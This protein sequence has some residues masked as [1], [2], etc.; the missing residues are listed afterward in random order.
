MPYLKQI[1]SPNFFPRFIVSFQCSTPADISLQKSRSLY[2]Q[3]SGLP[4]DLHHSLHP[5]MSIFLIPSTLATLL[6]WPLTLSAAIPR[7]LSRS[8]W[9]NLLF[10][11]LGHCQFPFPR[12]FPFQI[13]R[14][15]L[16]QEPQIFTTIKIQEE[17]ST[18]HCSTTF[19]YSSERA[20][21]TKKQN[22][23]SRKITANN[24]ELHST[25]TQCKNKSIKTW[26]IWCP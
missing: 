7:V 20:M 21:K 16:Y 10:F 11:F 14:N 23:Y 2:Q 24:L 13:P 5:S 17:F 25:P 6:P 1:T 9:N 8:S 3:S 26:S 22:I 18:R 19:S 12:S 4:T 15:T